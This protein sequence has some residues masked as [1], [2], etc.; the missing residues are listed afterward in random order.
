M[1]I[2][3]SY[4]TGLILL[5][6]MTIQSAVAQSSIAVGGLDITVKQFE[7]K[8]NMLYVK[9]H[10]DM[11]DFRV[12]SEQTLIYTPIIST[13]TKSINFPQIAL[14][15]RNSYKEYLRDIALMTKK[16]RADYESQPHTTIKA[17]GNNEKYIDYEYTATYEDW[18]SDS[19]L[20]IATNISGYRTKSNIKPAA[21]ANIILEVVP[22]ISTVDTTQKVP[23]F[24]D[25]ILIDET[26]VELQQDKNILKIYFP[27][28]VTTIDERY[29]NNTKE[30]DRLKSLINE[31]QISDNFNITKVFIEGFASI[32]GNSSVNE[33]LARGRVNTIY[34]YIIDNTSVADSLIEIY[35]GTENWNGL[36]NMVF[37][38]EIEDKIAILDIIDNVS[39]FEG[40]ETKL[41]NLNGGHTYR[42]MKNNFFPKLRYVYIKVY[43][44]NYKSE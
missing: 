18:M 21:L 35:S 31:I 44:D 23:Q 42:Y 25:H 43:L 28:N 20:I 12:K 17:F 11:N 33:S 19:K 16:E 15:G 36:R 34:K 39:I 37:E 38:S 1:K 24:T 30:L 26:N 4:I 10:L 6:Q 13:S 27:V 41:M 40:K 22:P 7:Q 2:K 3:A 5:L 8:D 32:E 14:M 29:M 9:L